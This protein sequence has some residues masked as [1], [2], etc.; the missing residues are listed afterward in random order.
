MW[1]PAQMAPEQSLMLVDLLV[2]VEEQRK[3]KADLSIPFENVL[4]QCHSSCMVP[5]VF[6]CSQKSLLG[7]WQLS[8]SISICPR[9]TAV[10]WLAAYFG[11]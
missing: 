1:H 5:S 7:Q 10:L 6:P 8:D 3:P 4:A 11:T 9:I 2:L